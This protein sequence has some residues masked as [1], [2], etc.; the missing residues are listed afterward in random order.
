MMLRPSCSFLFSFLLIATVLVPKRAFGAVDSWTNA[1][2]GLWSV[3]LNWSSNQPPDSTFSSILI[4]N[5]NSK[6][7]S[8]DAGT[9]SINLSIQKLTISAPSDSTNTLALVDVTTNQ[10]QLLGGLTVDHGGAL[11][12][13]NSLMKQTGFATFDVVNGSVWLDSGAI[14]CSAITAV[15]LGRTNNGTGTLTVNNGTF[16]ASQLEI[17]TTTAARGALVISGG[18]V[19]ASSPVTVGFGVNSTGTVSVAGGQLVATNDITY[20]GKSGFGQMTISGG[21][22]AFAFLSV[23]NNADGELSL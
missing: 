7:V 2:G 19:N 16:L 8:I 22:A 20:V 3:P 1:G 14:D 5:H 21:N 9:P 11:A 18:E 23:G 12:L 15:R 4:T 13:T 17:G 10:L 6:T